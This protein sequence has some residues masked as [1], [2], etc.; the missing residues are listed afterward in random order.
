MKQSVIQ[1][2]LTAIMCTVVVL[3]FS[4]ILYVFRET[5][6]SGIMN[7]DKEISYTVD[8]G[9]IP[10][11]VTDIKE[12][13]KFDG[14]VEYTV[15]FESPVED[16]PP[17]D[18]ICNVIPSGMTL[19][20][21]Y[22]AEWLNVAAVYSTLMNDYIREKDVIS[23]EY[24]GQEITEDVITETK[25]ACK[26]SLIE[27]LS[28]MVNP[29]FNWFAIGVLGVTIVICFMLAR[30]AENQAAKY[31]KND[32]WCKLQNQL[33]TTYNAISSKTYFG[34]DVAH[35]FVD[36]N[37]PEPTLPFRFWA[38]SDEYDSY[39]SSRKMLVDLNDETKKNAKL[40]F[41]KSVE[42]VKRQEMQS[43]GIIPDIDVSAPVNVQND[44]GFTRKQS[45]LRQ[46]TNLRQGA[47]LRR[48]ATTTKTTLPQ[49]T[50]NNLRKTSL[51]P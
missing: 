42:D 28:G 18:T 36:E 26:Q 12:H 11:V 37:L 13:N 3:I 44:S 49:R 24:T 46:S 39:M 38:N 32:V 47:N 16:A 29:V 19:D 20:S 2:R 23:M 40:D 8:H 21:E 31:V 34:I 43:R 4:T 22:T 35:I 15:H 17:F 27:D 6:F 10:Y 25:E 45:T 9:R 48:P 7:P 30:I 50:N 33:D 41:N 51:R 5:T 14:S 1:L